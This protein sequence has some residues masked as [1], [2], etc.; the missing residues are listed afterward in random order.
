MTTAQ[1]KAQKWSGPDFRDTPADNTDTEA[2]AF[3]FLGVALDHD[4]R[5]LAH[6][7]N[8]QTNRE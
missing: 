3:Q 8:L 6:P 4:L 2:V 1:K 5:P 7:V